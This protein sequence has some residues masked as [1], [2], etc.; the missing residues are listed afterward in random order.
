MFSLKTYIVRSR[1]KP[2][3]VKNFLIFF[4]FYTSKGYLNLSFMQKGIHATFH[5]TFSMPLEAA[6]MWVNLFLI[7]LCTAKHR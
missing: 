4:L 3:G 7:Y 5:I 2:L 1:I 6:E